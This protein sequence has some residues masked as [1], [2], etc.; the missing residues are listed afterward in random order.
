MKFYHLSHG[1]KS[2]WVHNIPLL[3]PPGM[4]EEKK[5][6]SHES[7]IREVDNILLLA[8]LGMYEI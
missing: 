7:G 1:S 2:R 3:A 5:Q 8:P 4:Y 6:L